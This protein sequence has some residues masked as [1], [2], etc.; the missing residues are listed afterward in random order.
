MDS[1]KK[2]K[3]NLDSRIMTRKQIALDVHE[4]LL[5]ITLGSNLN[6]DDTINVFRE[7]TK[8][9][10]D[11]RALK[12]ELDNSGLMS[13]VEQALAKQTGQTPCPPP[14]NQVLSD[15]AETTIQ[16]TGQAGKTLMRAPEE[17]KHKPSVAD[18]CNLS[19]PVPSQPVTTKTYKYKADDVAGHNVAAVTLKCQS[20]ISN[21]V[22]KSPEEVGQYSCDKVATGTEWSTGVGRDVEVG[23]IRLNKVIQLSLSQIMQQKCK[24]LN[25]CISSQS[26]TDALKL[27]RDTAQTMKCP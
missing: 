4:A 13:Y 20:D 6:D 27:L 25:V 3:T 23:V 11:P 5:G 16:T 26:D 2:P 24:A 1:C 15:S 19:L 12:T 21:L 17:A 9:Q 14:A 8:P 18:L 10:I 7:L 22:Q